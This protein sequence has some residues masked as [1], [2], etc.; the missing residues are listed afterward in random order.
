MGKF[1]NV[2]GD[3]SALRHSS[4][5]VGNFRDDARKAGV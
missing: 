2:P 3:V 4:D 1:R 5:L